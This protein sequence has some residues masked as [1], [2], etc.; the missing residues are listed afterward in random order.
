MPE[1]NP[2]MGGLAQPEPP[3]PRTDT[4]EPPTRVLE[5]TD[6]PFPPDPHSVESLE[7]F[8]PSERIVLDEISSS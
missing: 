6:L 1:N 7:R 2:K 3:G 8:S 5:L 4:L